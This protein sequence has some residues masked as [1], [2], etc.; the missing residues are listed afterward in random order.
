VTEVMLLI[1]IT[2][3][4]CLALGYQLLVHKYNYRETV[5]VW[6]RQLPLLHP[7]PSI[8][9]AIPWIY[10]AHILAAFTL[11]AFWPF[12]P[13]RARVDGSADVAP[14]LSR[15]AADAGAGST[16]VDVTVDR[17]GRLLPSRWVSRKTRGAGS[18]AGSSAP[19]GGPS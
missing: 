11:F 13:A 9:S 4:H 18:A 2:L 3:G 7:D 5:S 6:V 8:M 15:P 10:Q 12:S 17:A 14:A 16:W 19:T 1:V